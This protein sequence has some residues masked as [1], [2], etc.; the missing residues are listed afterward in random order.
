MATAHRD[1]QSTRLCGSFQRRLGATPREC[2][3]RSTG[4]LSRLI[5]PGASS[6]YRAM[7]YDASSSNGGHATNKTDGWRKRSAD[8]YASRV[9]PVAEEIRPVNRAIRYLIRAK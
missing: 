6:A 3:K 1:P 8:F 7:A 2:N 5:S 4:K 9:T